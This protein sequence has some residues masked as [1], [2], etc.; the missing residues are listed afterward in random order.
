MCG[1]SSAK[2]FSSTFDAFFAEANRKEVKDQLPVVT[3]EI[4]DAWLYGV[5]PISVCHWASQTTLTRV[6]S[7]PLRSGL[8]QVP[9][10]PLSNAMLW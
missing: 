5:S 10:D 1:L 7:D 9:S 6:P 8:S 4:G 2:V 3:A